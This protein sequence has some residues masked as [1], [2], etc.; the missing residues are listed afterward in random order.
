MLPED[1]ASYEET[2]SGMTKTNDVSHYDSIANLANLAASYQLKLSAAKESLPLGD[3]EWYPHDT[4]GAFY[5]LNELLTGEDRLIGR[6]MRHGPVLDLCCGDGDLA[7]FLASQEFV[8]DAIDWPETN[9]S[10]M[11]ALRAMRDLLK[12]P[13]DI[14]ELD[15][16]ESFELPR[17]FYSVIFL[18]GALYHLKNP[19]TVLEKLAKHC[20]YCVLTTRVTRFDAERKVDISAIPVAY[21]TDR[22]ETN[23]DPTNYY[24]FTPAGLHRALTRSNWLV[25]ALIT[26]GATD[27]DPVTSAGDER[28]YCFLRS[29]QMQVEPQCGV[30]PEEGAWR[31][32]Q[33]RFT[34]RVWQVPQGDSDFMLPVYIPEDSLARLGP[35]TVTARIGGTLVRSIQ[36]TAAGASVFSLPVKSLASLPADVEFEVDKVMPPDDVDG[37]ERGIVLPTGP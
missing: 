25:R 34:L 26:R 23:N 31:W 20:A 18:M 6:L 10:H 24:F 13:V 33:G 4:L 17:P 28:A 9:Y 2:P 29:A 19:L 14:S 12:L 32:T 7:F 36:Y 5:T 27:S 3:V 22:H 16:N 8:V 15:L 21:L 30:H 35:V 11:I 1:M 37:R